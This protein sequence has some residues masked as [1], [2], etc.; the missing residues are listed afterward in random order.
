VQGLADPDFPTVT[1]YRKQLSDALKA[2]KQMTA[3]PWQTIL[4]R[5]SVMA[6]DVYDGS[7]K[8]IDKLDAVCEWDID[9]PL[10]PAPVGHTAFD[11]AA[12]TALPMKCQRIATA[13]YHAGTSAASLALFQWALKK[14]L[15]KSAGNTSTEAFLYLVEPGDT[16][17]RALGL[18]ADLTGRLSEK[19]NSLEKLKVRQG[20]SLAQCMSDERAGQLNRTGADLTNRWADIRKT[21]AEELLPEALKQERKS[22]LVETLTWPRQSYLRDVCVSAYRV[23]GGCFE[24]IF[25]FSCDNSYRGRIAARIVDLLGDHITMTPGIPETFAESAVVEKARDIVKIVEENYVANYPQ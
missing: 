16:K 1:V 11:D 9:D 15:A 4:L 7:G 2:V 13:E 12:A 20:V 25:D 18:Y 8:L 23:T 6:W 3:G 21:I 24:T 22:V 10:L 19:T 14:M 5:C 17:C